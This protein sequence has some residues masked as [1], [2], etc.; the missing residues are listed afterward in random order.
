MKDIG[1]VIKELRV[2]N[3]ESQND[4]A[5]ELNITFQSI[6]KWENGISSPDIFMLRKIASHYNVSIDYLMSN[7]ENKTDD[8]KEKTFNITLNKESNFCVF[9]DTKNN[10]NVSFND[11]NRHRGPSKCKYRA[12]DDE[13]KII[14][15]INNVGRLIY[16]GCKLGYGYASPSDQTYH[17][18]K[19]EYIKQDCFIIEDGFMAF[20]E[21]K[22]E[23]YN[24]KYEKEFYNFNPTINRKS[25]F[26]IF[27]DNEH[28]NTIASKAFYDKTRH[29]CCE[30]CE[31]YQASN[32]KDDVVIAIDHTGKI[33][34]L[35][36]SCGYGYGSPSDSFYKSENILNN[37]LDCF[38][39]KPSFTFYKEGRNYLDY[40]FV[41]PKNGYVI[42]GNMGNQDFKKFM[43]ALLTKQIALDFYFPSSFGDIPVGGLNN[44]KITL[45]NNDLILQTIKFQNVWENYEFVVPKGGFIILASR[46]NYDT[47]LLLKELFLNSVSNDEIKKFYGNTLFCFHTLNGQ[48][49]S[50]RF[51]IFNQCLKVTRPFSEFEKLS[52]G[53]GNV[54]LGAIISR[55]EEMLEQKFN[56][57]INDLKC[58][59]DDVEN[60]NNDLE[61]QIAD[62]ESQNSDLEDQIGDLETQIST[63]EDQVDTLKDKVE[64]LEDRIIL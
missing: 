54:D 39:I 22:H 21:F 49:N 50:Y 57:R 28:L 18:D 3:N 55:V 26:S 33:I 45:I 38:L 15:A 16:A 23:K 51:S 61:C 20:N 34:Y 24:F 60:Q 62:L 52:I 12:S 47:F 2:K 17:D 46:S 9:D 14:L 25:G 32:N 29:R 31:E 64:D 1:T 42:I 44:R 8:I 37:K 13:N 4:L 56:D 6:S 40:E 63:L 5:K 53:N 59:I 43:D 11:K 41:I 58:Q 30:N 27:T 7:E 19:V 36:S 10:L 48:F 35:A